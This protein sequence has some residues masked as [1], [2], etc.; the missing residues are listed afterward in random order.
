MVANIE[1]LQDILV[2]VKY[3]QSAFQA[4]EGFS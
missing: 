1:L 4:I 2:G 3:R